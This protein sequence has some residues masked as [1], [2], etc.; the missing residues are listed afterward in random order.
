LKLAGRCL[1]R[2]SQRKTRQKPAL[3]WYSMSLVNR[4]IKSGVHAIGWGPH[5]TAVLITLR[6]QSRPQSTG[7]PC[8]HFR[9]VGAKGCTSARGWDCINKVSLPCGIVSGANH[10]FSLSGGSSAATISKG[11]YFCFALQFDAQTCTFATPPA[12]GRA[13]TPN[14]PLRASVLSPVSS[15][16]MLKKL[17]GGSISGAA[18]IL[19]LAGGMGRP[20][21]LSTF[22][23]SSHAGCTTETR[24]CVA[25]RFLLCGRFACRICAGEAGC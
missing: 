1:S 18:I 10:K 19:A 20:T 22:L 24:S 16:R 17:G 8:C 3:I 2:A 23:P 7:M 11:S 5:S 21:C 13:V 6:A 9:R 14:D 25:S 12:S 15:T 4:A